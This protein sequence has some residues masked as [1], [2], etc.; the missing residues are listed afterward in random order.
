MKG[1]LWPALDAADGMS[2]VYQ[3][4]KDIESNLK[5]VAPPLTWFRIVGTLLNSLCWTTSSWQC[6]V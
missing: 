2:M 6:G 5:L 4:D 1:V 3:A